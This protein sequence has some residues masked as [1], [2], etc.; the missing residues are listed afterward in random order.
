M[1]EE[2]TENPA[3]D[4]AEEPEEPEVQAHSA[5]GVLGLQKLKAEHGWAPGMVAPGS[6]GSCGVESCS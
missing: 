6:T 1:S 3:P 2:N 5:E 4:D